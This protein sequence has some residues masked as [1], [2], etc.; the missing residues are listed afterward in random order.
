MSIYSDDAHREYLEFLVFT[1][2]SQ[3]WPCNSVDMMI[4]VSSFEKRWR[5]GSVN[6]LGGWGKGGR[7]GNSSGSLFEAGVGHFVVLEWMMMICCCVWMALPPNRSLRLTSVCCLVS[8]VNRMDVTTHNWRHI[9][10]SWCS[11]GSGWKQNIQPLV[12]LTFSRTHTLFFLLTHSLSLCVCVRARVRVSC[13]QLVA[14][15]EK[16]ES[17]SIDFIFYF[18]LCD[19][20][21]PQ[22]L[23]VAWSGSRLCWSSESAISS[24]RSGLLVVSCDCCLT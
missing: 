10:S 17:I 24:P 21:H 8:L 7:N 12:C 23:P 22:E 9:T 13:F 19:N 16:W 1:L 5:I 15:M 20:S 6:L 3:V 2:K 14:H 18:A 4:P 11:T